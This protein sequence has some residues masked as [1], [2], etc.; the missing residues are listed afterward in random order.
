MTVVALV[1]VL[2][3][4][5]EV[6]VNTLVTVVT[7]VTLVTIVTAVTSVTVARRR[8]NIKNKKKWL[9]DKIYLF[10]KKWKLVKVIFLRKLC[11]NKIMYKKLHNIFLLT[12]TIKKCEAINVNL[13]FKCYDE[14]IF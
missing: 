3:V 8:K 13:V 7:V 14:S 11:Q 5:T 4:V 2:T 9:E 6:T 1:K 10:E 12:T